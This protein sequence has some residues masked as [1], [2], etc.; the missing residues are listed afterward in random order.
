MVLLDQVSQ[1]YQ[2]H[3]L[4]QVTLFLQEVHHIRYGQVDLEDRE[5]LL[6]LR[7]L[8]DLEFLVHP[9]KIFYEFFID[10]SYFFI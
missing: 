2:D 9:V 8:V 10:K 7:V 4:D 5:S 6:D 1:V 3:L